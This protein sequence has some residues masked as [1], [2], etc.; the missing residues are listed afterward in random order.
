MAE[1]KVFEVLFVE[2]P[3]ERKEKARIIGELQRVIAKDAQTAVMV[4]GRSVGAA[5]DG[6]DPDQIEAKVRPF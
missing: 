2:V 5:L 6:I 1:T 3:K 4:A